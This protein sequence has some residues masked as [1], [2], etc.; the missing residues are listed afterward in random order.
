MNEEMRRRIDRSLLDYED[1]HEGPMGTLQH[2][3]KFRSP[4]WK[5]HKASMMK[6]RASERVGGGR[7][8]RALSLSLLEGPVD[9]GLPS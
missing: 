2:Q 4:V 8:V 1:G 5:R 6:M 3:E 7:S 9:M